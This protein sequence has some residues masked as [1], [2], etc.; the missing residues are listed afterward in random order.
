LSYNKDEIKSQTL[1]ND[2]EEV[3]ITWLDLSDPSKKEIAD[4]ASRFG[5]DEGALE[6]YFAK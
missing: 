3:Y 4:I 6:T 5:L 1:L 2:L